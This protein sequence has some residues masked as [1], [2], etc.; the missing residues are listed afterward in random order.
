MAKNT[1]TVR[2]P[3]HSDMESLKRFFIQAYGAQTIFQ[4]SRF[5]NWYFNPPNEHASFMELSVVGVDKHDSI[6]AHYGG[7]R[8]SLMLNRAPV[9]MVWGV[10]AYTLPEWRGLGI[11][12][13]L[14]DAMMTKCDVYGVIGFSP[15]T[16]SF[17]ERLGFNL[18]SSQKFNRYVFSLDEATFDVVKAIERDP[19]RARILLDTTPPETLSAIEYDRNNIVEIT[20]DNLQMFTIGYDYSTTVTTQRSLN[21]LKW[22]FLHNPYLGYDW[23]AY[24]S[25]HRML[26]YAVVRRE[27]LNPTGHYASRI[28]DLYGQ[29]D[30]MANVLNEV[31]SR[32][33]KRK[34]IF[35]DFSSFGHPYQDILKNAGFCLLQ[36]EDVGLL[37]QVTAPIS[38]RPNHEYLGLFS[39]E[40]R[41]E[42]QSLDAGEVYF[43]RADSDR[44]RLS[45]INQITQPGKMK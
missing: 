33:R 44:D 24:V 29:D 2:S 12:S 25:E 11:N 23:I 6:V 30:W 22:R 28:I 10:N 39:V 17:Y 19:V 31:K 21:H 8:Y 43:T 38:D 7:L 45:S 41:K 32:A 14:V 40:F 13:K 35:V 36:N 9:S 1:Y 37:P 4:D 16:V 5:L 15:E 3:R 18:F 42:I 26:G 27:R 34:D 20:A